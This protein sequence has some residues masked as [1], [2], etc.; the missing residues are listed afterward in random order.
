[1]R[2]CLTDALGERHPRFFLQYLTNPVVLFPCFGL[3]VRRYDAI[4][5]SP[6]LDDKELHLVSLLFLVIRATLKFLRERHFGFNHL[7]E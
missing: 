4:W 1:L 2:G 6:V 7:S 3:A 5:F